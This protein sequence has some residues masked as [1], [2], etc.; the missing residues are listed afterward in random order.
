MSDHYYKFAPDYPVPLSTGRNALAF[1]KDVLNDT[2]YS[3]C[4]NTEKFKSK[5]PEGNKNETNLQK[6]EEDMCAIDSKILLFSVVNEHLR[7]Y[8]DEAHRWMSED[9]QRARNARYEPKWLT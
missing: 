4:V 9:E 8:K 6:N 2:Y 1:S 3:I 5:D 7:K